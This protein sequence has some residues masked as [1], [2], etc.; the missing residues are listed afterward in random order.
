MPQYIFYMPLNLSSTCVFL[1]YALELFRMHT[2]SSHA[3]YYCYYC[4]HCFACFGAW[5]WVWVC[6]HVLRQLLLM[7][8]CAELS[9]YIWQK[10]SQPSIARRS[11]QHGHNTNNNNDNVKHTHSSRTVQRVLCVKEKEIRQCRIHSNI[12]SISF[13]SIH[14]SVALR[15][16]KCNRKAK[17][18]HATRIYNKHSK[19]PIIIYCV[20]F[21]V[22]VPRQA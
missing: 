16:L 17:M 19:F 7:S 5:V 20:V 21:R 2:Y 9:E 4:E 13:T 22:W 18:T 12:S 8:C 1:V 15:S 3:I 11:T 10:P 6:V 14:P